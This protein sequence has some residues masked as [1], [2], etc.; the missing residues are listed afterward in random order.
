MS[1]KA[2][3]FSAPSGAGKTTIVHHLLGK[4]HELAF[5]ISA[6][7]RPKRKYELDGRDYYFISEPDFRNRVENDELLEWEEVYDGACYGTLNE[8]VERI[9]KEGKVVV[10]DVD[11]V[12]GINLK[13]KLGVKSMAVFIAV[14]D[15]EVLQTRLAKRD[16]E[17]EA[18][19]EERVD[20]ALHEMDSQDKFDRVLVNNDL[21]TALYDAERMVIELLRK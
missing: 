17:D 18:S 19:L 16:T 20:K 15:V 5:S 12:G 1:G 2:L 21:E 11:V 14:K 4:F 7:T 9:W 13:K 8:E 6:T 3:I 10:F